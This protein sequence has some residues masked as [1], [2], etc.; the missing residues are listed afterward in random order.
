MNP[1]CLI[2]TK[3]KE[4]YKFIANLIESSQSFELKGNPP[5]FHKD[6][7]GGIDFI[8][9]DIDSP[10]R[11]I[12]S[13]L[14]S[15]VKVCLF[16]KEND[17]IL[18]A[19]NFESKVFFQ[20]RSV[21]ASSVSTKQQ[22]ELRIQPKT[23]QVNLGNLPAAVESGKGSMVITMEPSL[24]SLETESQKSRRKRITG[25]VIFV[26]SES[27]IHRIK[28]DEL[29]YVEALKD[30]V[31]VHAKNGEFKILN[32]MKNVEARLPEKD[33]FRAHRSYI[34]RIDK[35]EEIKDDD[36]LTEKGS[37][38]IGPSFRSKLMRRLKSL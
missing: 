18:E 14:T 16:S 5:K 19:T 30:Y 2:I 25:D 24:L 21:A 27:R 13:A 20:S 36:I 22:I 35:I 32:S 31:V 29:Y 6:L 33:F 11:D 8:F 1:S 28:L 26:K 9:M 34:V 10:A 15:G 37:I 17:L 23:L 3:K 4:N 38:P 7:V 12:K